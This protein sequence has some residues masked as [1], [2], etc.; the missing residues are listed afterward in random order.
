MKIA[1][2][3]K[4]GEAFIEHCVVM[5][6][7][8]IMLVIVINVFSFISLKVQ[9]DKM[10][11]D[12]LQI[13]TYTGSFGTEF[14]DAKQNLEDTFF[15]FNVTVTASE[16]Y[17]QADKKVQL[18]KVMTVTVT[19]DTELKGCGGFSIPMTVS[20]EHSGLSEKYWK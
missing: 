2:Y 16:W 1:S 14:E 10:S 5:V 6:L 20:S 15:D 11:D 12:L 13:A 7:V 19:K 9:L 3:A 8:V 4:K 17:S 18:G